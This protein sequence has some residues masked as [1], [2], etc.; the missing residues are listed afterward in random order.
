[1]PVIPAPDTFEVVMREF[2]LLGN[3]CVETSRAW[4]TALFHEDSGIKKLFHH[5]RIGLEK[6]L[7]DVY[8][9]TIA[10]TSLVFVGNGSRDRAVQAVTKDSFVFAHDYP[11]KKSLTEFKTFKGSKL[12]YG[13]LGT[14]SP[15][16][17]RRFKNAKRTP[18]SFS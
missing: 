16:S 8:Q 17:H 7:K 5:E 3:L 10:K 13:V 15:P 6:S 9:K 1:M 11:K 18:G 12:S 14:C 4:T 2:E